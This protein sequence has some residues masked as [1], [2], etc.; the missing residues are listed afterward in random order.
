[1]TT[2][3]KRIAIAPKGLRYQKRT[4]VRSSS[5]NWIPKFGGMASASREKAFRHVWSKRG[6]R[7]PGIF[8]FRVTRDDGTIMDHTNG[9][10]M[11]RQSKE[12]Y[13]GWE[14]VG[15]ARKYDPILY[16]DEIAYWTKEGDIWYYFNE[17]ENWPIRFS[18]N[19]VTHIWTVPFYVWSGL[20]VKKGKRFWVVCGFEDSILAEYRKPASGGG[21]PRYYYR[22]ED[23]YKPED[24]IR[25][26]FY[27]MVA[28]YYKQI[29]QE[30][31][32]LPDPIPH[33][34]YCS[35]MHRY[36]FEK[37]GNMT[38]TVKSSIPYTV[39]YDT[40]GGTPSG[41]FWGKYQNSCG[42]CEE[43]VIL[44]EASEARWLWNDPPGSVLAIPVDV[45]VTTTHGDISTDIQANPIH[46][47]HRVTPTPYVAETDVFQI[48]GTYMDSDP[49]QLVIPCDGGEV[50]FELE[51]KMWKGGIYASV[52][53]DS[54]KGDYEI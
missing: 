48:I 31:T 13:P 32:P 23:L 26:K 38:L 44:A 54:W 15:M 39:S 2:A 1:M 29:S 43:C 22:T 10:I 12:G 40:Y 53:Y 33:A 4:Q 6:D 36:C 7:R 30:W 34:G 37:V 24:Y 45:T 41:T 49:Y 20:N 17:S 14:T 46:A 42:D 11:I 28:P 27:E 18:Y 35:V 9:V 5:G 19:T 52:V 3:N 16:P 50:T 47:E 8:S 25:P 51:F 21:A